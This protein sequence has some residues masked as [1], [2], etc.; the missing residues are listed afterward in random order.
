MSFINFILGAGENTPAPGSDWS[1]ERLL[2]LRSKAVEEIDFLEAVWNLGCAYGDYPGIPSGIL[3]RFVR[4][5][6]ELLA[7][8]QS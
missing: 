4:K 3:R 8:R 5:I 7:E 1:I 6:D 2:E